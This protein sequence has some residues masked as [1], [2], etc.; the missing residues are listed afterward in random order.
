MQHLARRAGWVLGLLAAGWAALLAVLWFGQERLLFHPEPLPAGHRFSV[1]D[2]VHEGWVDVPGARLNTLHL[3]LPH[4]DGV[5]FFL[6][7]NAG[8]LDSWFVNADFYRRLNL[9]LF[10][11]DYRGFGKSSGHIESQAQLQ[12]DVA[13]AW[14]SVAPRYVGQ[15]RIVYGR[16]LGTGLA[17]QLAADIQPELTVLVSPYF[18]M[19]A[20]AAE[21]YPWVPASL[22][23]YPLRTDLVISQVRGPLLLVHGDRDTLIPPAHSAQ[24]QALA[25][26]SERLLVPGAGHGDLQ[27]FTVYVEAMRRHCL[28][29]QGA[30]AQPQAHLVPKILSP[31]SP[32]PGMM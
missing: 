2:D 19:A 4:P 15:R 6:H 9:D 12:A 29:P 23:R 17:A 26:H 21:H 27:N 16:S 5:V 8:N 3:R 13:A 20:L 32:R 10:M 1:G 11:L 24:L 30:A 18:S 28:D 14:A 25:P 31:A 22:L 7:G